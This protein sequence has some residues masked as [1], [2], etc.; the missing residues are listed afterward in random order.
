M[1][2]TTDDLLSELKRHEA[3]SRSESAFERD[4]AVSVVADLLPRI[5]ARLERGEKL[6]ALVREAL[7]P[8]VFGWQDRYEALG[9]PVMPDLLA[10]CE[11]RGYGNVMDS[12]SRL[13]A[14]KCEREGPEAGAYHTTAACAV[15][16]KEWCER[17]AAA[18]EDTR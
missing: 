18:L 6:E 16:R 13:W 2:D 14:A 3:A 7:E 11:L 1:S 12:A 15:I 8:G 10:M 9:A 17:A 4:T 5:I